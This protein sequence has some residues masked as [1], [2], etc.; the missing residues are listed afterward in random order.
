MRLF[1]SSNFFSS[2]FMSDT[3][4]FIL[5][6]RD[7]QRRPQYCLEEK[8]KSLQICFQKLLITFVMH[9]LSGTSKLSKFSTTAQGRRALECRKIC[10]IFVVVAAFGCVR[11]CGLPGCRKR[12]KKEKVSQQHHHH[13]HHQCDVFSVFPEMRSCCINSGAYSIA[14]LSL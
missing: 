14:A 2:L 12:K 8:S 1:A 10:R 5:F 9:K 11:F 6:S 3:F 4:S 13:R 7:K